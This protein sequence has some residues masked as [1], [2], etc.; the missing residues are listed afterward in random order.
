MIL[1]NYLAHVLNSITGKNDSIKM[2]YSLKNKKYKAYFIFAIIH[3]I[4]IE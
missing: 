2:R 3:K 1:C 4:N